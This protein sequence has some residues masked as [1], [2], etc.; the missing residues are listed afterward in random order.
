MYHVRQT[1]HS[2]SNVSGGHGMPADRTDG[3]KRDRLFAGWNEPMPQVIDRMLNVSW[4]ITLVLVVIFVI[5][6]L[7]Q[8]PGS[9]SSLL[10]I[11][12]ARM[13]AV[14]KMHITWNLRRRLARI[15]G[16]RVLTI[17]PGPRPDLPDSVPR[18]GR[19]PAQSRTGPARQP[20]A[21][22]HFTPVSGATPA[23]SIEKVTSMRRQYGYLVRRRRLN[24]PAF[25]APPA[26]R[27]L[28]GPAR[29]CR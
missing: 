27:R 21:R 13:K 4:V 22:R 28:P 6:W 2:S 26:C 25:S 19:M 23:R 18:R 14:Q 16:M 8:R 12:L 20:L 17:L 3:K 10:H 15:D 5:R 11:A 1:L 29:A 9:A 7:F 24:T